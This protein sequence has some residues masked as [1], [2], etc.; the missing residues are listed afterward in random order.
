VVMKEFKEQDG[1][2][3]NVVFI[4]ETKSNKNLY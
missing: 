2:D 1:N 3:G 4:Y